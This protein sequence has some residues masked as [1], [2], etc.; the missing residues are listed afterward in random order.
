MGHKLAAILLALTVAACGGGGGG[1]GGGNSG[2]GTGG[3]GGGFGGGST[4]GT[5][6]SS[7]NVTG[8]AYV[9]NFQS[10]NVS[11]YTIDGSTGALSEIKGSPFAAGVGPTAVAVNR[12]GTFLYVANGGSFDF[13]DSVS[14][15][16]IDP[17]T[18]ALTS[19]GATPAG[20]SSLTSI[21]VADDSFVYTTSGGSR[22]SSFEID[23]FVITA[24][25]GLAL[26]DGSPFTAG[27][28]PS[29]VAVDQSGKF[30]YVT[31]QAS[32][33]VSSF[34]IAATGALASTGRVP[35]AS[36][37]L[38][39]TV[40]PSGRFLYVHGISAF[41]I[42]TTTGALTEIEGSAT[43]TTI[44]TSMSIDPSGRFAYVSGDSGILAYAINDTTGSLTQI[45]GSPFSSNGSFGS[46]AV[47]RSGK[48]V[49]MVGRGGLHGYTIN[50]TTGALTEIK[51]SPLPSEGSSI[52][53][54]AIH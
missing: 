27:T 25:G 3:G 40:H 45:N 32:Q 44:T 23:A 51:G 9:S 15:F 37:P 13:T 52:S 28:N 7:R 24:N 30:A 26:V 2:G 12:A 39:I 43:T 35:L 33:D 1:D 47:D 50:D 6:S 14:A 4:G 46:V 8:F 54:T 42:D 22:V 19:V 31:N 16:T 21:A 41:S 38:W 18:G 53:T 29:A 34:T 11:A 48:F 17:A 36:P 10:N 20:R 49:Y 5:P